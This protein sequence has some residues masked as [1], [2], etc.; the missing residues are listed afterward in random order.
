[1][2][3]S[4]RIEPAVLEH[5]GP[6]PFALCYRREQRKILAR[7]LSRL[8]KREQQIITL[9]YE[10]ELTMK[11]IGDRNRRRS[12]QDDSRY[13]LGGPLIGATNE[14]PRLR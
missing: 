13:E 8:R 6:D 11:Q 14:K 10:R 5:N 4:R 2:P 12:W 3:V 9:Y 1:M 7:A